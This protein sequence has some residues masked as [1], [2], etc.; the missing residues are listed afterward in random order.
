MAHQTGSTEQSLSGMPSILSDDS[1]WILDSGATDHMVC[2]PTAL[3]QSYPVYGRTIQLPDGSYASITHI[4]FVT[5]SP[6]LVL[7]NVLCVPTFHFNL[8][9]VC[10]LCRTLHCIIIFSSD[11]CFISG[12]SLDDNDWSGH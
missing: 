2:S 10:T 6:S 8:I 9:S 5:F 3:T 11:F 1:L 12:P 4:G 7:H